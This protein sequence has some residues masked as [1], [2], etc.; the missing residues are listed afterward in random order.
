MLA[1]ILG[2]F[3]SLSQDSLLFTTDFINLIHFILGLNLFC[4][5]IALVP[6]TVFFLMVSDK[7]KTDSRF[8]LVKAIYA[9]FFFGFVINI[10]DRYVYQ[11]KTFTSLIIIAGLFLLLSLVMF[12]GRDDRNQ[13]KTKITLLAKWYTTVALVLLLLLTSFRHIQKQFL[14]KATRVKNVVMIVMDGLS[15]A[16]L[17]CYNPAININGFE[18]LLHKSRL[19]FNARTN[20][21]YTPGYFGVL[22]AGRKD[23]HGRSKNLL[24][25][26]QNNG[27][28]TR[29]LTYHDNAFPD[30]SETA[31]H[32]LRS[33][34]LHYKLSWL[35][36]LLGIDYNINYFF[37]EKKTA[38]YWRR[39]SIYHFINHFL[40]QSI[41]NPLEIYLVKE[42]EQLRCDK[43]PFFLLMHT[44]A[45]GLA[46]ETDSNNNNKPHS[47]WNDFKID[48]EAD[49][50]EKTIRDND[51]RYGER[52]AY[53]VKEWERKYKT[54]VADGIGRLNRFL[55]TC[56]KKG[57]L[58]NTVIIITADHGQIHDRG[59]VWYGFH[60]DEEVARVPLIII[61][62]V[63]FG[64]DKRLAETI[65]I[66]QTIL[67]FLGIKDKFSKNS[68][69]LI[70][71]G[72]KSVVTTLTMASEKRKERFLNIY[73]CENGKIYKYSLNLYN[74]V[75][76]KKLLL[77]NFLSRPIGRRT[78]A[79]PEV[80]SDLKDALC[81]YGLK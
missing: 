39:Y 21:T 29:W 5:L 69:S 23:G 22:Y 44:N 68:V 34:Y 74:N 24:N 18:E 37:H 28:N 63:N 45:I 58:D 62:G 55:N 38:G 20:Y 75:M 72:H 54:R 56:Q 51:Y 33:L 2:V 8:F 59:K 67:S 76:D 16:V 80:A 1:A 61:D 30:I 77:N 10:V 40:G 25:T 48:T 50:I 26:L 57:W 12:S 41:K 81:D 73:K 64:V 11:F 46:E 14:Y 53:L 35:P 70:D 27:I 43:R 36:R 66:S 32:G 78:S 31:Y 15:T 65:D 3:L 9:V 79:W 47:L 17:P 6:F 49:R 71:K 13:L 42:I 52:E 60:N 7:I 19:F 4:L